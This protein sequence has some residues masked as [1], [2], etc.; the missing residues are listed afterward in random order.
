M[1]IFLIATLSLLLHLLK[2][3]VENRIAGMPEHLHAHEGI[4][5]PSS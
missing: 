2:L 4:L 3:S 5:F 1:A